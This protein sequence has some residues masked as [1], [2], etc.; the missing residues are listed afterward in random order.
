M[1]TL[2][3]G[4]YSQRGSEGIYALDFDPDTGDLRVSGVLAKLRN[5]SFLAQHPRE[6]WLYS[7][8]EEDAAGAVTA[9]TLRPS[10]GEDPVLNWQSTLG[11]GPCHVA[12]D[13]LGEF[14]AAANYRSG[15]VT[16]FRI[17]GDGR[18]E[19][20]C[21]LAQHSGSGPVADR[22]AGPHAHSVNFDSSGHFLIAADLGI[23]RLMVYALN[24]EEG[25][26]QSHV[27]G[28]VV[29]EPGSGPRH[30]TFH[31]TGPWAYLISELANTVIAYRW[32]DEQ[33]SLTPLQTM[34]TLPPDF[35]GAS[36]T[37]EVRVHPSG[38]FLYG[39]NRGHDSIAIFRLD[40]ASGLLEPAGHVPTGGE[41]PRHFT[42][43]P[44]GNW[45]LV[46]NMHSDNLVVFRIGE[47]G[48]LQ[49]TGEPVTLPSPTCL[50]FAR[51]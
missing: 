27:P 2:Y 50:L 32:D 20:A 35:T 28:G 44:D 29:V 25:K 51:E 33:G 39:S 9:L 8:G 31:P 24:R 43:S 5:P 4:T 17:G 14:V 18:L 49:A 47:D 34:P 36:T 10:P 22:Q 40:P 1:M 46:A 21:D 38:R 48:G 7:T 6:L 13:P 37:A 26:L 42:V 19:P 12:V 16:L 41:H 15:G 45:L 11:M 3:A 23:D 30:F